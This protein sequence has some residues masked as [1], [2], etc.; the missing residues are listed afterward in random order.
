VEQ[1]HVNVIV[2]TIGL[3]QLDH[4]LVILQ[5]IGFFQEHLALVIMQMDITLMVLEDAHLLLV[6][7]QEI[8]TLMNVGQQLT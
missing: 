4:V 7:K 8:K 2:Q 5:I 1:M 6:R 3:E